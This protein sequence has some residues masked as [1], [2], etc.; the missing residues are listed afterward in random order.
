MQHI[1]AKEIKQAH[2]NGVLSHSLCS[3]GNLVI[4]LQWDCS[5]T[6]RSSLAEFKIAY[7]QATLNMVKSE[8]TVL[9]ASDT[10]NEY[11]NRYCTLTVYYTTTEKPWS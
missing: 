1:W 4:S 2:W 11:T 7:Y 9:K 6:K 5:Y 10:Q 3:V 8:I